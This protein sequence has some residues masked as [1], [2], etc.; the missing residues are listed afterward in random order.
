MKMTRMR[1]MLGTAAVSA[2]VALTANAYAR[3]GANANVGANA[4]GMS[5]SHIGAQ[6]S[7]NTNG[8]NATDRNYGVDRA[9]DRANAN[10]NVHTHTPPNQRTANSNGRKSTDRDLGLDRA[11][12]RANEN[13][14]L[15]TKKQADE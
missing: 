14:E 12:E 6:G 9:Q 4:G 7:A 1:T 3:D 10:A 15:D 2:C 8:P 5:S 13:A 11:K